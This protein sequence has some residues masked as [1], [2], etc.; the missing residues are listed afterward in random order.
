MV[1]AVV[2]QWQRTGVR[3]AARHRA[4]LHRRRGGGQRVRR[5]L[6]GPRAPRTCSTAAP[7]RSARSAASPT[8]ISDDLRLYLIETAEKGIDWLR[9][10]ATGRPGHGSFVHDDNAVTALCRGGR[11][12]RP[13]PLPDRRHP[14]RAGV[15]GARSPR[16]S[17]SSST[18]TTRRL[19]IA[20]LGPIANLIGATIRNTA[21]PT[22]LDAGYKDNV[23]PGRASATI[24]CRT[25][26]R[27]GRDLPRA[28]A[29][30]DRPGHRDRVRAAAAGAGDHLRRRPG[31]RDG[32]RAARRGPGRPAGAVH[33][34]RRHR[35]QGVHQPRHPLLRLRPAA[36]AAPTSTS[37][38]CSTA[39]TSGY[40]STDY[41]SACGCSTGSCDASCTADPA[42]SEKGP[43]HHD[44]PARGAGRRPRAR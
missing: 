36:A 1:L 9:L 20:K 33:A 22:R 31:R 7:R 39:S 23:I 25:P 32:R 2:R 11:P 19:A 14:D 26:A 5:A 30:G 12:G 35:R 27:P 29:R 40:R 3:P 6:P 21:N 43:P 18:R 28:A 38:R 34:L 44:R 41:S 37:P 4:G 8:P 10:H 15:P 24:D 42:Q 17:A 13:A 16:R